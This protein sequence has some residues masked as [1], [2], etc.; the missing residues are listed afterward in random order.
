MARKPRADDRTTGTVTVESADSAAEVQAAIRS[1]SNGDT[2]RFLPGVYP[3][4]SDSWAGLNMTGMSHVKIIGP[5]ATLKL[6]A[7]PSQVMLN[8]SVPEFFELRG[9]V[10][11]AIEDLI[12]DL[13]GIA[14]LG[15]GLDR[16]TD[17]QVEDIEIFAG[18]ASAQA[19]AFGGTR[20]NWA[21]CTIRDSVANGV[22]RG[23]WLGNGGNA[24]HGETD[25]SVNGCKIFNNAHT[26]LS[27]N[28]NRAIVTGNN[29]FGNGQA[30]I[31]ISGDDT[32]TDIGD[33]IIV[34]GNNIRDNLGSG[35]SLTGASTEATWVR[36]SLVANNI[37]RNNRADGIRLRDCTGIV[38]SGNVCEGNAET[39][40][41]LKPDCNHTVVTSNCCEGND[42]HGI[43]AVNGIFEGN[44]ITANVVRNNSGKGIIFEA[45]FPGKAHRCTNISSNIVRDN[46]G[47]GIILVKGTS[48]A[49]YSQVFVKD[50]ICDGNGSNDIRCTSNG[51]EPWVDSQITGN[52]AEVVT[53][54]PDVVGTFE[55]GNS[56]QSP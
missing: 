16:C 23:L 41:A 33:G 21:N 48:G 26:G 32:A 38:V 37:S 42:W 12:F 49:V 3:L 43:S 5:G 6:M 13:N 15:P 7:P 52:Y 19:M 46:A 40:I 24:A 20:N 50:N 56:W 22:T 4:G 18:A 53:I 55:T 14:A 1:L 8:A 44:N 30:G 9:C 11:C 47:E 45:N 39:G 17:T 35:I 29:I 25:G 36:K 54:M 28:S 31:K 27:I 2:L 10:R 34:T 51:N